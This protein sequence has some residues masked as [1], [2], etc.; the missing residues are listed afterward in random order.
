MTAAPLSAVDAD[1][2]EPVLATQAIF[3]TALA[4]LAEPGSVH[5]LPVEAPARG[6]LASGTVALCRAL[7]DGDTPVWL[8]EAA[9]SEWALSYL[10]FHCGLRRS[11]DA[12]AVA[13]AVVADARACPPL[14]SFCAGTPDYPDRSTTILLQVDDIDSAGAV[15]LAG[16]GIESVRSF[17]ATPLGADFWRQVRVNGA[18]YPLGVDIF[19]I[20]GRRIAALPRSTRVEA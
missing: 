19:F 4:A 8:D 11:R 9:A 3:R 14:T 15:R 5:V 17:A 20:A 6:T 10:S 2:A 18:R 13:F 16:P 1:F 7:V 12:S